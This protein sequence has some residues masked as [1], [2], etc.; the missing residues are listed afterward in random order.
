MHIE[1]S[2]GVNSQPKGYVFLDASEIIVGR[3]KAG[4]DLPMSKL[5][6][7]QF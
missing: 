3:S 6:Q 5:F 1:N 7:F 2:N 4:G